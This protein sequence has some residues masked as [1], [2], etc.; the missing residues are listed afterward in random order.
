M[1]EQPEEKLGRNR[2][3]AGPIDGHSVVRAGLLQP[4]TKILFGPR[5]IVPFQARSAFVAV[6]EI[7]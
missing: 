4:A 5:G 1:G 6:T 7:F 2:C 3:N